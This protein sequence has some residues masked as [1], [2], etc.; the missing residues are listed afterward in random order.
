[1]DL[2]TLPRVSCF[3]GI[4]FQVSL[5]FLFLRL[6]FENLFLWRPAKGISLPS[7]FLSWFVGTSRMKRQR[8]WADSDMRVL[9]GPLLP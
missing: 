9:L 8:A 2:R 5:A 1:M 4:N 6:K 3:L 7:I